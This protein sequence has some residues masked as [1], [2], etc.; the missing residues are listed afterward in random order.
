MNPDELHYLA[1]L[2]KEDMKNDKHRD[3]RSA[4]NSISIPTA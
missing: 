3:F 2:I 1:V 4:K